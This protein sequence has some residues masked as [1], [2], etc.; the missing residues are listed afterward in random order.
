MF[1]IVGKLRCPVCSEPV[2]MDEKV[3][4][5]IINT[6]IHQR[7]YYKSPRRLPIKDEGSF[8]KMLMKYSF[9]NE[10]EED[11]SM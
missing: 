3:F 6:V 8:Q 4:L 2:Q 7:C 9:F 1:E 11:D 5:D 10:D